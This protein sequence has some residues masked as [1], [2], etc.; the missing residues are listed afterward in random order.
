MKTVKKFIGFTV[1]A[2]IL[3]GSVFMSS[4]FKGERRSTPKEPAIDSVE[5]F[6]QGSNTIFDRVN[7]TFDMLLTN[8]ERINALKVDII[9][10][11]KTEYAGRRLGSIVYSEGR[12]ENRTSAKLTPGKYYNGVGYG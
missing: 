6:E 7:N 1:I 10:K 4:I 3:A 11:V 8:C 12:D 5:H 2:L 9:K